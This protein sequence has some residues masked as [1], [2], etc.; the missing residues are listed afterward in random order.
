MDLSCCESLC[1]L[2]AGAGL[3]AA[4]PVLEMEPQRPR[5]PQ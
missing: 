1:S 3:A 4:V 5:R 2:P